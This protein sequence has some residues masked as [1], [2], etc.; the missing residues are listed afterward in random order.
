LQQK[1]LQE[2]QKQNETLKNHIVVLQQ[3]I[4]RQTIYAESQLERFGNTP[5]NMYCFEQAMRLQS[6]GNTYFKN[7]QAGH[8]AKDIAENYKAYTILASS[9]DTSFQDFKG[10][11]VFY[12][13][14][15]IQHHIFKENYLFST[16]NK[17]VNLMLQGGERL[18]Y[19]MGGCGGFE[20]IYAR[21]ILAYRLVKEGG[22]YNCYLVITTSRSQIIPTMKIA[23]RK[24]KTNGNEGEISIPYQPINFDANGLSKQK[25]EAQITFKK[26]Y[27]AM[28]D[29]I[30]YLSTSYTVKRKK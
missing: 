14:Q 21:P 11:T 22:E 25:I 27:K 9:L 23:N 4:T 15:S 28:N 17:L 20:Q 30:I 29:T 8:D 24:V 13:P 16:S 3:E 1:D 5:R 19:R 7:L 12:E 2:V 18:F 10:S 26:S 6:I